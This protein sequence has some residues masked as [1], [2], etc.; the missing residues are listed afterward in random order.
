MPAVRGA[1]TLLFMNATRTATARS[2][3]TDA[4]CLRHC[5]GYRVEA[6]GRFLGYVEEV[7]IEPDEFLAESGPVLDLVVGPP[8]RDTVA[9]ADV[10]RVDPRRQVVV[11]AAGR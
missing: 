10:V 9:A 1:A 7:V 8:T 11:V 6:A 5:E 4:W 2:R 3:W